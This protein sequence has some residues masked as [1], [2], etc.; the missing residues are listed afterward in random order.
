MLQIVLAA[1]PHN[2]RLRYF[3]TVIDSV[4][5]TETEHVVVWQDNGTMIAHDG[6]N[7]PC[8][9]A[10]GEEIKVELTDSSLVVHYASKG[11]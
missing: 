2:T 5:I 7:L 4:L 3:S 9:Q 8:W 6:D 1:I 11:K 10:S